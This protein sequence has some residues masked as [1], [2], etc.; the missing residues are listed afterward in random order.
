[1]A[2]T[3]PLLSVCVN[4]PAASIEFGLTENSPSPVIAIWSPFA[5]VPKLGSSITSKYVCVALSATAVVGANTIATVTA[6][7]SRIRRLMRTSPWS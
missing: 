5:A 2:R 1:V 4:A 3:F 7:A 6:S